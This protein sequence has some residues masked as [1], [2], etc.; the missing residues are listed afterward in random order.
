M[1][2]VELETATLTVSELVSLAQEGPVI[3]T[4]GGHPCA[5]V[6]DLS[7]SDLESVTLAENPAF[8]ALIDRSRRSYQEQGGIP[9]SEV[10]RELG[11]DEAPHAPEGSDVER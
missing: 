7:G 11:L 8:A 9:L 4:R 10:R 5:T 6:K 1:K 2:V 3:L